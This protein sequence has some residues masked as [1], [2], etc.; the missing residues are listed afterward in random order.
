MEN[1][2]AFIL[3]LLLC[4]VLLISII[5]SIINNNILAI[6]ISTLLFIVAIAYLQKRKVKFTYGNAHLEV[7]GKDEEEKPDENKRKRDLDLIQRILNPI[8]KKCEH[9]ANILATNQYYIRP[10]LRYS[11][12]LFS[13]LRQLHVKTEDERTEF[14]NWLD[15]NKKIKELMNQHN[16]LINKINRKLN[17]IAEEM[18]NRNKKVLEHL[19]SEFKEDIEKDNNIPEN[20]KEQFIR[21]IPDLT[22]KNTWYIIYRWIIDGQPSRRDASEISVKIYQKLWDSKHKDLLKFKENKNIEVMLEELKKLNL[23]LGGNSEELIALIKEE[24]NKLREIHNFSTTEMEGE[25]K[26]SWPM[27]PRLF[28]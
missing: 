19:I 27:A 11:E 8:L 16:E 23:E 26:Q 22:G 10:E 15:K 18:Q 12:H 24:R 6:A 14:S 28:R 21:D 5:L 13:W 4:A 7:G 3:N 17:D 2:I 20:E 1:K 9:N 25:E